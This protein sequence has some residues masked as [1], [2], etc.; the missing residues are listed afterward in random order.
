MVEFVPTH[1]SLP[2]KT[3]AFFAV[4]KVD[5]ALYESLESAP[6]NIVKRYA[7]VEFLP[8]TI[9]SFASR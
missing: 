7:R 5:N 6:V 4:Y 1:T 2:I 8:K 3:G 9:L